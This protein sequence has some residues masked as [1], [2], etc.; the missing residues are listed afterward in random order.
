M[1]DILLFVISLVYLG[2]IGSKITE[3]AF[4]VS[5]FSVLLLPALMLLTRQTTAKKK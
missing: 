4:L 1:L 3:P 2:S 5:L